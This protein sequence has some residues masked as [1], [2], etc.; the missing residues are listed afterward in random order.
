MFP[1]LCCCAERW[2]CGSLAV[3]ARVLPCELQS[4]PLE[5][6]E[7]EARARVNHECRRLVS[8][9]VRTP[10]DI[11]CW[12]SGRGAPGDQTLARS[13]PQGPDAWWRLQ[14]GLGGAAGG[15]CAHQT[16]DGT[17][18]GEGPVS[19]SDGRLSTD[20]LLLLLLHREQAFWR[21]EKILKKKKKKNRSFPCDGP[22][23]QMSF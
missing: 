2:C 20:L 18:D 22:C 7:S 13:G 16:P 15:L 6:A 3:W 11:T 8:P 23:G 9:R 4:R 12:S 14:K 21:E 19:R 1:V 17:R 5:T 10:A